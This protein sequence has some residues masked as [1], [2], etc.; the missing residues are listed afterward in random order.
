MTPLF[1]LVTLLSPPPQMCSLDAD[2]AATR[3]ETARRVM[4][5]VVGAP[6]ATAD[7]LRL[8]LK[9]DAAAD[10]VRLMLHERRCCPGTSARVELPADQE[11]VVL[12]LAGPADFIRTVRGLLPPAA[13]K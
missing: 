9:P 7:G 11:L 10:A 6:T 13:P 12:H 4:T 3:M 5:R 8:V 2:Q 1:A